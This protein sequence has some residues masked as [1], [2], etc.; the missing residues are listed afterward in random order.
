MLEK[1]LS[2]LC[3]LLYTKHSTSPKIFV[4]GILDTTHGVI[5]FYARSACRMVTL[6]YLHPST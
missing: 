4:Q 2:N 5:V 1:I 3:V 6:I